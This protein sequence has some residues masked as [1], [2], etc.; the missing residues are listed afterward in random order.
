MSMYPDANSRR[1]ELE[2]G[3]TDKSIF[4]FFNAVYAWM[5]VGLALTAAVAW[6]VAQSPTMIRAIYSGRFIMVAAAL[7]MFAIAIATQSVAMRVSAAAGT[8]MF[9]LYAALMGVLISGI[10]IIYKL[11]T[12]GV[13]FLVTGGVFGLMSLI[14]YTTKRDLSKIGPILIAG[15]IGMFIASIVNVFIAS[16]ILDWIITY[17]VLGL[18]IGITAYKTQYLKMMAAEYEGQPAMLARLSVVGSLILY[19]TF[20]N[21][22]MSVLRILGNRR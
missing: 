4:N 8:A 19:I 2:Y 17:A 14:G 22:F 15:M 21:M 5:A 1:V 16:S 7:G 9:L 13:S 20:I 3:T 6:F 10:F 18:T 12:I 11:Q